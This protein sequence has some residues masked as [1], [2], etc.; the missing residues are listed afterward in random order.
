[1]RRFKAR[2]KYLWMVPALDFLCICAF[3]EQLNRFFEI[4]SSFFNRHSLTGDIKIG[5]ER[6]V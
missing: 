1:M 4:C 2:Y 6:Y 5:T 3:Q